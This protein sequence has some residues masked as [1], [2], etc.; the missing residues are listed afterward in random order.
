MQT[1]RGCCRVFHLIHQSVRN[2]FELRFISGRQQLCHV[3]LRNISSLLFLVF[4]L[5]L[6]CLYSQVF[7]LKEMYLTSSTY[8]N[9][10][11]NYVI[12]TVSENLKWAYWCEPLGD[13]QP[14]VNGSF[15]PLVY[16]PYPLEQLNITQGMLQFYLLL[17]FSYPLLTIYL[18]FSF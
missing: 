12:Q 5:P 18:L 16:H 11:T 15:L 17:P 14:C 4:F 6:S 8:V 1:K 7:P 10:T 13:A 2:A 3:E 9:T